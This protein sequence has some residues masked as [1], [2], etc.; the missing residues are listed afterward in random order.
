M[1]YFHHFLIEGTPYRCL[2]ASRLHQRQQEQLLLDRNRFQAAWSCQQLPVED[3][4]TMWNVGFQSAEGLRWRRSRWMDG[5][6]GFR[7]CQNLAL[8]C[9]KNTTYFKKALFVVL[10]CPIFSFYI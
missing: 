8:E 2:G 7:M 1:D 6:M 3:D 9:L 5:W 4:R 10:N